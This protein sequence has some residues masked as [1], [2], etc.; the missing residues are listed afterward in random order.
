[1]EY[2]CARHGVHLK[3]SLCA[4]AW[5]RLGALAESPLG[6]RTSSR[7][8]PRGS[9]LALCG[10]RP[11]PRLRRLRLSTSRLWCSPATDTSRSIQ[12]IAREHVVDWGGK[13]VRFNQSRVR[14][15]SGSGSSCMCINLP[16]RFDLWVPAEQ[17]STGCSLVNDVSNIN[18]GL[19]FERSIEDMI[20]EPDRLTLTL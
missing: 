13:P 8:T 20:F 10:A 4:L 14:S 3:T 15:L 16:R 1:M 17:R 5:A 12:R 18:A 19:C 2:A 6:A 11:A 7:R 9:A